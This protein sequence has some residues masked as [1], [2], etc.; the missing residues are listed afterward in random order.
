MPAVG[1]LLLL[2]ALALAALAPPAYGQTGNGLYKPFPEANSIQRSKDFVKDLRTTGGA[3]LNL[4][5]KQLEDGVL[6]DSHTGKTRAAPELHQGA[7]DRADSG[8]G[9]GAVIAWAAALGLLALT[10]TGVRRLSLYPAPRR[11]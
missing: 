2:G 3:G 10:A 5:E 9:L 8:N 7:S 1:K 4:S 11:T 6:V